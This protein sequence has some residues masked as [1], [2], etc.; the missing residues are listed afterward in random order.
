M[1]RRL[2][3]FAALVLVSC[4]PSAQPQGAEV[5]YVE[6]RGGPAFVIRLDGAAGL[7]VDCD[8][9][10]TLTPGRG[11][12][13]DLPWAMEVTRQRDGVVIFS[14]QVSHLPQWYVQ[15]GD[16]VLG[17]NASAVSGPAGPSCPPAIGNAASTAGVSPQATVIPIRTDSSTAS[18]CLQAQGGGTL[19]VD[20]VAGVGLRQRDGH[21]L[22]PYW[23]FDWTAR[24]DASSIALVDAQARVVAHVG[25]FISLAGGLGN[26]DDWFVCQLEPVRVVST[27]GPS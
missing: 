26:D 4:T 9:N 3:A 23:P 6:N 15:I 12:I 21:V 18:T 13:P 8:A 16:S 1:R 7:T 11:G 27:P 17:L 19:V 20:T 25:D 2:L 14:G 22:H 24:A 5:L 10:P